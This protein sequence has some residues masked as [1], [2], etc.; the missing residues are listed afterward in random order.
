MREWFVKHSEAGWETCPITESGF[1]RVSSNPRA[2]PH[3]IDPGSAVRFLDE[4][5]QVGSHRFLSDEVS[6]T[7]PD[8]P[9][10]MATGRSPTLTSS[11]WR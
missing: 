11:L 10:S 6:V 4:M 2:L 3:H 5:R 1:V 8:F 9:P 7:D